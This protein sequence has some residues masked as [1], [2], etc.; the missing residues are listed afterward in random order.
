MSNSEGLL[1]GKVAII[2][3]AAGGVGIE[4][5]RVL[6][7]AGA[8]VML[9]DLATSKLDSVVEQLRGEGL[10]VAGQTV[11]IANEASVK[12]LIQATLD[13][14]GRLDILD[15]NAASQGQREDGVI[16]DMSVELWD[17][18]MGVNARGAMLMC[19]HAIPALIA[20]GGGS[21]INISSGTSL[22]GDF[23]ATAYACSKGA[24]NTLTKY[25]AT[26]YAAQ[27]IRCNAL[28]LGLIGTPILKQ[29][30]PAPMLDIF[31][32]HHMAGRIGEPADV[33]NMVAFLVSDRSAWI[34]G[35]VY[36]V[37]GGFYAHTPTTVQVT[38]LMAQG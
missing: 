10:D 2:S 34:T 37:D 24:V 35:Q 17:H 22:A 25:V 6:A 32:R 8:R 18:I 31:T 14:F 11:D 27:G 28:T 33:A 26:Q 20:A 3:G 16:G 21:I 23:Y 9:A 1:S 12:A 4:T 30:M 5:S 7:Q 19:K 29:A 36:S 38:N 15:N 13:K